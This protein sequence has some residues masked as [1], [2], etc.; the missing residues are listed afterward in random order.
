MVFDWI[1]S[2]YEI[3]VLQILLN[4]KFTQSYYAFLV[5]YCLYGH[6]FKICLMIRKII[7][8]CCYFARK[9]S[10][11]KVID[12]SQYIWIANI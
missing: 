2:T 7:V 11:I 1:K 8:F 4:V 12:R 10:L 6:L 3:N 9:R 5:T